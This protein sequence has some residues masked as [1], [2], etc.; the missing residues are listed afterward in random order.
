LIVNFSRPAT[1]TRQAEAAI[2]V[3]D[4]TI[5]LMPLKNASAIPNLLPLL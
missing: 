3:G 1:E 5:M 4:V 2:V